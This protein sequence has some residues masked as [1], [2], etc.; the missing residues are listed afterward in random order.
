MKR[1]MIIILAVIIF[2]G[3][4]T[5]CG[6]S[7]PSLTEQAVNYEDEI[8]KAILISA[9]QLSQYILFGLIACG[10]LAGIT[11]TVKVSKDQ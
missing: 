5:G 10:A 6:D 3:I 2:A 9:D 8:A 1:Y 11:T 7:D 4:L